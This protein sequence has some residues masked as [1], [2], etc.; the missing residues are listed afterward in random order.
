MP[1]PADAVHGC[2]GFAGTARAPD[3]PTANCVTYPAG[4]ELDFVAR[5]LVEMAGFPV[6]LGLL[7]A[8]LARGNE[9]PPDVTRP[10][11]RRAAEDDEMG[12]GHGGNRHGVAGLEDEQ[13]SGFELVAGNIDT[14]SIT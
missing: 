9:I 10:I 11:H 3:G 6:R 13:A 7:D 5:H 1:T 2:P 8:L 4:D 12:V 14:P